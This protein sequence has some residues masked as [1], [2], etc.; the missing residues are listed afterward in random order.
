[1]GCNGI[2]ILVEIKLKELICSTFQYKKKKNPDNF[3]VSNGTKDH[4]LFA[5]LKY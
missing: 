1:M 2:N 4:R 3:E 5:K